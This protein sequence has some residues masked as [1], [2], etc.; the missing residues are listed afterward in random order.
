MLSYAD[1]CYIRDLDL[2]IKIF[3]ANSIRATRQRLLKYGAR[4]I[5]ITRPNAPT[6]HRRASAYIPDDHADCLTL[7]LV[8]SL[9]SFEVPHGWFKHFYIVS[10]SFSM[11]WLLEIARK[12]WICNFIASDVAVKHEQTMTLEQTC[13][14][15]LL[16]LA[17]GVRRAYECHVLNARSSSTMWMG[18]WLVGLA[19]YAAM[20]VAVWV[21]GSREYQGPQ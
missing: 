2:T 10:V 13:L 9:S 19:F 17:Q 14:L 12:G 3:T 11:F 4:N 18:H 15:W 8:D 20:S 1:L 7:L 6:P 5:K 21:E 16:M